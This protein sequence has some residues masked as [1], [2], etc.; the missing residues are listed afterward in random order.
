MPSLTAEVPR[1]GAQKAKV[2]GGRFTIRGLNLKWGA[3]RKDGN[4]ADP[5]CRDL[6]SVHICDK[7]L[8]MGTRWRH[9]IL[10]KG[11]FRRVVMWALIVG[12]A[13]TDALATEYSALDRFK[14][15][16]ESRPAVQACL[17]EREL[18]IPLPTDIKQ[19]QRQTFFFR[20]RP[21][22]Y[23]LQAVT[24]TNAIDAPR[25]DQVYVGRIRD[26]V[27]ELH[28]GN[29]TTIHGLEVRAAAA[30]AVRGIEEFAHATV[31]TV[32]NLGLSEIKPG[33]VRWRDDELQAESEAGEVF[34]QLTLRAGLP[35]EIALRHTRDGPV[36]AVVRY[37]YDEIFAGGTFP[38][39]F[40]R[41]RI[42]DDR[43]YPEVRITLLHLDMETSPVPLALFEPL[44][45][46][47]EAQDRF[48]IVSNDTVYAG[49]IRD[50]K[51]PLQKAYTAAEQA[52]SLGVVQADGSQRRLVVLCLLVISSLAA[53]WIVLLRCRNQDQAK[54][55]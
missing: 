3:E 24:D 48:F 36:R 39:E 26:L 40:E 32:L 29:L 28:A 50:P 6:N 18:R 53:G 9:T 49:S 51:K 15:F 13:C 8:R 7:R 1:A 42:V 41:Y 16:L 37:R 2:R 23:Y 38:V 54:Q 22:A 4:N 14:R 11:G 30:R 20:W 31:E 21:D 47:P 45:F 19:A 46:V 33:S 44:R 10:E 17:F 25:E 43:E 12:S 35:A 52:R 27:W 34:G 55:E 5:I